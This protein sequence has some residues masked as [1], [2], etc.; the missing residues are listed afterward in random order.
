M[1]D[2]SA[3]FGPVT[4]PPRV[5]MAAQRLSAD[6]QR[7]VRRAGALAD[8]ASRPDSTSSSAAILVMFKADLRN[9]HKALWWCRYLNDSQGES[10]QLS[11]VKRL[12]ERIAEYRSQESRAADDPDQRLRQ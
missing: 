7:P 1:K 10:E 11:E 2:E 9:A 3:P 4:G 8:D 12:N 5:G 6:G